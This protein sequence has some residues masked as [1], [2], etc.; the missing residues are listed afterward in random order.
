MDISSMDE[1][2]L[3]SLKEKIS[4]QGLPIAYTMLGYRKFDAIMVPCKK[5]A[6]NEKGEEIFIDTPEEEQ[7]KIFTL[8]AADEYRQQYE[9][10]TSDKR[11]M[12]F[13]DDE[14]DI[15]DPKSLENMVGAKIE[16]EEIEHLVEKKNKKLLPY[17]EMKKQGYNLTESAEKL[18]RRV[19]TVQY[20]DKQVEGILAHSQN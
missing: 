14:F 7:H 6:K 11:E 20:W 5:T 3:S 2:F 12:L 10:K 9:V 17:F 16:M 18:G 4:R 19:S 1:E 8:Y 15:A 13:S